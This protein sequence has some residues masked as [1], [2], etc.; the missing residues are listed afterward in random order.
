MIYIYIYKKKHII[1]YYNLYIHTLWF[2]K[3]NHLMIG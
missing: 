2:K 1:I 3:G